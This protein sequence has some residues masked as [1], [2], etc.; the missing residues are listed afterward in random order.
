MC[1][2]AKAVVRGNCIAL[3]AYVGKEERSKI[4]S[5]NLHLRKLEKEEIKSKVSRRKSIIRI[6]AEMSEIENRNSIENINKT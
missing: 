1:D 4:N 5:I 3:N 2:A 6:T